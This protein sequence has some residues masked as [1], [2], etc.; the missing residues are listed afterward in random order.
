MAITQ[1][2]YNYAFDECRAAD[3]AA[4]S[5][6]AGGSLGLARRRT[7]F[8]ELATACL[9]QTQ[10]LFFR[11]Q[12]P[13]L[14]EGLRSLLWA[15][16]TV[17]PALHC[18]LR[19]L[20]GAYHEPLPFWSATG[21][22]KTDGLSRGGENPNHRD[23]VALLPF[24]SPMYHREDTRSALLRLAHL[25][26]TG[27]RCHHHHRLLLLLLHHLLHTSTPPHLLRLAHLQAILFPGWENLSTGNAILRSLRNPFAAI[28]NAVVGAATLPHAA[29]LT[30][31][32][33]DAVVTM[34]G[35]SVRWAVEQLIVPFLNVTSRRSSA[36]YA[37]MAL[38]A[39]ARILDTASDF[40][41]QT[42]GRSGARL[43][44]EVPTSRD[45]H[46]GSTL[47]PH[48]SPLS[49][50][51]YCRSPT[52]WRRTSRRCFARRTSKRASSTWGCATTRSPSHTTSASP[53]TSRRG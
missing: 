49:S 27:C 45:S 25:Q 53:T 11:A 22:G 42:V 48:H 44:R 36:A 52:Y 39:L 10:E 20:R 37:M 34:A 35:H 30:D 40:S 14:L 28:K 31:P 13:I 18:V 4:A 8:I 9:L 1:Q 2:W 43:Q 6:A 15:P 47:P 3:A 16:A 33:S 26:V 21:M 51:A 29:L 5:G 32:L 38:R 46:A 12:A 50:P 19:L 23:E 24:G 7:V 17:E 41:Q